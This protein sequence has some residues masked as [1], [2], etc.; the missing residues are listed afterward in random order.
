MAVSVLSIIAAWLPAGLVVWT[1]LRSVVHDHLFQSP[2]FP[3]MAPFE[4]YVP[5]A[6]LVLY[7]TFVPAFHYV[8]IRWAQ[9][10]KGGQGGLDAAIAMLLAMF[11]VSRIPGYA[12]SPLL[13][14]LSIASC[15]VLPVGFALGGQILHRNLEVRA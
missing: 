9:P 14:W 12:A 6:W 10:T 15:V 11:I 2:F 1:G 5:C 4:T 13:A 3:L 7:V 8:W